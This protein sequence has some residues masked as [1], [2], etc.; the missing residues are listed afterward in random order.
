MSLGSR[1]RELRRIK[2]LTQAQLGEMVG[3]DGNTVSRW[4]LDRLGM[5]KEYVVKFAKALETSAA[6][7][8][9]ETDDP[10]CLSQTSSPKTP[11]EWLEIVAP[12]FT[13]FNLSDFNMN[14]T[15]MDI[16]G[17]KR[18]PIIDVFSAD[19]NRDKPTEWRILPAEVYGIFDPQRPPFIVQVEDDSMVGAGIQNGALAIINPAEQVRD[20]EAALVGWNQRLAAIRL[21]YW[22]PDGVVELHSANPNYTKVYTFTKDEREM[23]NFCVKGKVMWSALRPRRLL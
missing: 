9:G 3:S 14:V 1:I 22:R 11:N 13:P 12:K 15:G 2:G 8:L 7:L 19:N 6:F 18:L 21:I 20:G 17:L 10:S 5:R 4:E 23:E 16:K